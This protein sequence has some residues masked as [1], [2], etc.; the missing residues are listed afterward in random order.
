MTEFNLYVVVPGAP[1]VAHSTGKFVAGAPV[2]SVE[3]PNSKPALSIASSSPKN[4]AQ[5]PP[6]SP[7]CH[8]T[9]R[10]FGE[11]DIPLP[12]T[13]VDT[14]AP[15]SPVASVYPESEVEPEKPSARPEGVEKEKDNG[16]AKDALFWKFFSLNSNLA[17]H[18]N[19]L[20]SIGQI[21]DCSQFPICWPTLGMR[22]MQGFDVTA[23]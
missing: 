19:L 20:T 7:W 18:I 8:G 9:P 22:P 15:G 13:K 11:P 4:D 16:K 3:E 2:K 23:C 14:P 6:W 17:Y 12:D 1:V 10:D 21:C 5:I